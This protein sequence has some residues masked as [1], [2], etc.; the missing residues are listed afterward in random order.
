MPESQ[1]FTRLYKTCLAEARARRHRQNKGLGQL[2]EGR[3]VEGQVAPIRQNALRQVAPLDQLSFLHIGKDKVVCMSSRPT[4]N[5]PSISLPDPTNLQTHSYIQSLA[6]FHR[7]A[8][9]RGTTKEM[10]QMQP[11]S[12]SRLSD[13]RG[14]SNPRNISY[15]HNI[16]LSLTFPDRSQLYLHHFAHMFYDILCGARKPQSYSKIRVQ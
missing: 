5:W 3:L 13:Q 16:A 1:H 12:F 11:C 14:S 6:T 9:E 7:N 4:K 8:G 10:G 2:V 15:I